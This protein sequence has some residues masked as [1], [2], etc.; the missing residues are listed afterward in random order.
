LENNYRHLASRV[1]K[2]KYISATQKTQV[3]K[4]LKDNDISVTHSKGLTLFYKNLTMLGFFC[5]HSKSLTMLGFYL[6]KS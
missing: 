3:K 5:T 4:V 6:N 2:H 1:I